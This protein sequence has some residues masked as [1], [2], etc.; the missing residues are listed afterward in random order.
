MLVALCRPSRDSNVASPATNREMAQ[1]LHLAEDS[2][3]SA[4]RD[5]FPLFGVDDLP[6]N[7]SAPQLAVNALQ[8]GIV[9]RHK[10]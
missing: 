4:L 8:T 2:V 10:L 5:L 7:Q 1:E 9:S 3:K 6:P